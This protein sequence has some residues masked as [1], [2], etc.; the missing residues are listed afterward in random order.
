MYLI[1]ILEAGR[2][3]R[4]RDNRTYQLSQEGTMDKLTLPMVIR[5]QVMS[6]TSV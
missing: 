5:S 2:M 4:S 1:R 6:N 3:P